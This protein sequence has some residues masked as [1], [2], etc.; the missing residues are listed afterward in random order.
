MTQEESNTKT[1]GFAITGFILSFLLPLLGIIFSIIGL[2]QAKKRRQKGEGLAIAGIVISCVWGILSV[3]FVA[4]VITTFTGI[5]QKARNTER[6][7]D[8]K[9]IHGQVEAYYAENGYYPSLE[10]L[11]DPA[12]RV[13]NLSGLDQEALRDPQGSANVIV[14]SPTAKSYSY[15]VTP[16]GCNNVTI[17]CTKYVLTANYEGGGTFTKESLN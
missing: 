11:N 10:N 8:I 16:A 13:S 9:A 3:I 12:W 14:S 15:S 2:T 5:Q 6:T 17:K 4:L 1:N 7:T